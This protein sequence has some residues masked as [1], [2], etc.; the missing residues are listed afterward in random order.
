MTSSTRTGPWSFDDLD[1]AWAA[2]AAPQKISVKAE[3]PR[4]NIVFFIAFPPVL[5]FLNAGLWAL[6]NSV[7]GAPRASAGGRDSFH[8][9]AA[10]RA[11][12]ED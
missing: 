3:A 2:P 8:H 5:L 12:F 1:W 11:R 10:A 6:G 9:H 4:R 7:G